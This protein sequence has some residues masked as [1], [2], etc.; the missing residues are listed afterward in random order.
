MNLPAHSHPDWTG[1]PP[2]RSHA[3]LAG[4]L[5]AQV[6]DHEPGWRLPQA[7]ALARRYR[8]STAE[9]EGAIEN[10]VASHILRRM[11]DGRLYRA[12]PADYYIGLEGLPGIGAYIDP[13][14]AALTCSHRHVSWRQVPD[15]LGASLGLTA[16]AICSVIRSQWTAGGK[17]AALST[18][19]IRDA[20][21]NRIRSADANAASLDEALNYPAPVNGAADDSA[22]AAAASVQLEVRPPA[23][24]VARYLELQP[25]VPAITAAVRFVDRA[26]RQPVALT[27]AAFRADLFRLTIESAGADIPAPEP[28]TFG[29]GA[30]TEQAAT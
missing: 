6:C 21:R 3:V 4:R 17:H 9:I 22:W 18:T 16:P 24:Y 1:A 29:D 7:T 19:Y 20:S 13:M 14:G 15:D 25:G 28:V 27:Y 12:S 23:R 5:A 30:Y 8:A 11:A 2:A 26:R 10:L